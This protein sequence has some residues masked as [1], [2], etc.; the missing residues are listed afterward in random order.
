[1][2]LKGK[3]VLSF[4][5]VVFASLAIL[6]GIIY[7]SFAQG[8]KKDTN[9][10]LILQSQQTIMAARSAL[11]HQ[12]ND[13]IAALS[14]SINRLL[15]HQTLDAGTLENLRKIADKAPLINSLY[16]YQGSPAKIIPLSTRRNAPYLIDKLKN[17]TPG[18]N[19]FWFR[20]HDHLYVV[21]ALT[22][23]NKK[24]KKN[25]L[26]TEINEQAMSEF[27]N[28]LTTIRGA[29][30]YL[31]RDKKLLMPPISTTSRGNNVKPPEFSLVQAALS[32]DGTLG[33][34]GPDL[35]AATAVIQQRGQLFNTT[36]FLPIPAEY[37]KEQDNYRPAH[38]GLVF[39]LDYP[40]YRPTHYPSGA[41]FEQINQGQYRL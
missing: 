41:A 19:D 18:K 28:S 25:A 17:S 38:R 30:I 14:P 24:N 39:Y 3:L 20:S 34:P 35:P 33:E 5:S 36:F 7:Y 27:I 11:Q 21:V 2:R 9:Q 10:I 40:C 29:T 16:L 15:Q 22:A 31:S 8:I 13:I 6:G 23:L 4:T 12:I 37:F 26:V 1:V 32:K